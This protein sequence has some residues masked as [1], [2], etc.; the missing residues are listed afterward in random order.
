MTNTKGSTNINITYY[1]EITQKPEVNY[2]APEVY[3][4]PVPLMAHKND[5]Y[6]F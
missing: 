3:A 5:I 2:N 4:V 6:F 1:T